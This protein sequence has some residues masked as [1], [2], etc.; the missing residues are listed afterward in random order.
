MAGHSVGTITASVKGIENI[1]GRDAYVLEVTAKTNNF[2]SAIYKVEDRFVSYMDTE[3]FYTL[4]HEVYRREGKYKKDAVTE[5]DQVN[6]KAYFENFLDKS[7][8]DF[9]IPPNIQDTLSA[10]YYFRLLPVEIGKRIEYAVCNNESNYQLFGVVESKEYI[11]LPKVG[12]RGAFHIQPYA[13][14]KGEKVKKGKVS[15]YFS[16]DSKRIP[17][18]AVV[19]AP[20]FTEV[21][22]SL[23]KIEYRQAQ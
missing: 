11:R 22:A 5:F 8:K 19:Q 15:G 2:C 17:L 13:K 7:K 9:D 16:T 14:L 6:H 20:M 10:S 3:H 4:R 23:E 12:K 21:N 18:L 1:K